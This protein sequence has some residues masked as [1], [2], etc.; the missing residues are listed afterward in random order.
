[1][2]YCGCA[3]TTAETPEQRRVLKIAL[4]LNSTMFVVGIVAGFEAHSSGLIADA[5]DMLADAAAYAI[6]LVAAS[7]SSLF[8][9]NAARTSGFILLALGVGVLVDVVRR[10][11]TGEAPDGWIMIV[12]AAVALIVNANVLRLLKKQRNE[13]VHFRATVSFT[14]V[15][16]IANMA[17]ILSGVIVLATGFRFV[18][19]TV[20]AAIGVCVVKEALEIIR[21]AKEAREAG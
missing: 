7:R 6:A 18:D 2:T 3:P 13:E 10:F 11:L 15:D 9:A 4:T 14:Q 17:V 20:G 12:V 16:V 1:M 8:K 19:L 21:E 5:L